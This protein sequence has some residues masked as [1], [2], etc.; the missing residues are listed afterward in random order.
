MEL[1]GVSHCIV[2]N[3]S[4]ALMLMQYLNINLF[5]ALIFDIVTNINILYMKLTITISFILAL[6]AS[7]GR[8]LTHI[9]HLVV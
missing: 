8:S 6:L 7:M 9:G 5:H 4:I 1:Y 2:V 3:V